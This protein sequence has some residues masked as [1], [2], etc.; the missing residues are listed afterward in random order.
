MTTPHQ[1]LPTFRDAGINLKSTLFWFLATIA[2]TAAITAIYVLTAL[3]A[4]QQQRFFDRLSNLQLPAFRPNFG[5]IL[6]YPLSVQLH[7]FTIAIAF[8]SGLIILLSPKGTSFHRTLGWVFVLAMITTAGASIMM[9]R[10]FTTGFNFLHIF[11]VVTVVSLYLALTGIKA[12]NVQRH[13]S[14]MFWLFV[15][16]ILIAGA[17]TFAPGRLMWRMFFGG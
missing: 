4:T 11:T 15:G 12:G 5:L 7:V 8:F 14:S 17:F 1:P 3:S 2:I 16:G 13:G 6:D 10:D 9:I